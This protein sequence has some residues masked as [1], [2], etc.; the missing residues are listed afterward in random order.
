MIISE[1]TPLDLQMAAFSV[2]LYTVF[3]LC[4]CVC[5]CVCVR[6]CVHVCVSTCTRVCV[7]SYKDTKHI[8][9]GPTLMTSF[10]LIP[11]VKALVVV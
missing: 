9:L 2:C 1:A 6:A 8:G 5:V 7:L 11:S 10:K 3:L 4:V